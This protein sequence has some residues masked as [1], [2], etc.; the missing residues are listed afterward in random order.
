MRLWNLTTG[1]L[2]AM[3]AGQA[4]HR[5]DVLALGIH[6]VGR[7]FASAGMDNSVKLWALD[8]AEVIN[9]ISSSYVRHARKDGVHIPL[10]VQL[11]AFATDDVHA[12]Y[13]DSV[14]FLGS[15]LAS[16]STANDVILWTP[17]ARSGSHSAGQAM[18]EGS[19][20][21]LTEAVQAASRASQ[22]SS[23]LSDSDGDI[24]DDDGIKMTSDGAAEGA[25]T[26]VFS[27]TGADL[28][29]NL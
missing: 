15:L 24:S 28:P 7:C 2:V 8:S 21:D 14:V 29:A 1:Q 9:A 11:P 18:L 4:G 27:A 19:P 23:S 6:P 25:S 20:R 3:F 12:D 26:R 13:A 10:H 5:D 22:S 16:K 17:D